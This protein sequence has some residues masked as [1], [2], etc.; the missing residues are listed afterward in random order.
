[1]LLHSSPELRTSS[2]VDGHL[3]DDHCVD[4]LLNAAVLATQLLAVVIIVLPFSQFVFFG[5]NIKI[6]AGVLSIK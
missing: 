1:M 2:L 5:T 6:L 3:F 4:L